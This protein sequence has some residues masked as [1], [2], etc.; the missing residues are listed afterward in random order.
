MRQ[1]ILKR[2]DDQKSFL[3]LNFPLHFPTA[4]PKEETEAIRRRE[5]IKWQLLKNFLWL[6]TLMK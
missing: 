5:E 1:A 4:L 6:L 3:E 2:E